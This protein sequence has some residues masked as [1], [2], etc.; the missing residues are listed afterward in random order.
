MVS[1]TSTRLYAV[2]INSVTKV[3]EAFGKRRNKKAVETRIEREAESPPCSRRSL[4][5]K[6]SPFSLGPPSL[7]QL[8]CN[9]V[10]QNHQQL[11][12]EGLNDLPCDV[13]QCILD[14]FVAK[15]DLT[16]P[17]LQLFRKQ[18]IYN[19]MVSD[20][21]EVQADWLN[22]L[23]T[24]PL[25]RVHLSRCS[26][27]PCFVAS[28]LLTWQA[29]TNLLSPVCGAQ[30]N[31]AALLALQHQTSLVDLDLRSCT[32]LTDGGMVYLGGS[33]A[34]LWLLQQHTSL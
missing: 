23:H 14:E 33:Y 24:A 29:T 5:V 11:T 27:V 25:R 26:Q 31:D 30:V 13:V 17:V 2:W 4:Q 15:D 19:F 3:R 8:S 12:A 22:L 10:C 16:L 18:S 32:K 34:S 1:F 21:P 9:A 7:L 6:P 28:P 20:L